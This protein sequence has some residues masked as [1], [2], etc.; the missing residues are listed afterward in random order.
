MVAQ[1][2]HG[3]AARQMRARKNRG[4]SFI[5]RKTIPEMEIL[6][7]EIYRG[8]SFGDEAF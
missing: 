7:L 2:P 6:S 5:M 3:V 4:I 1:L 8:E